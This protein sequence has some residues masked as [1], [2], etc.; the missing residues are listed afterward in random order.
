MPSFRAW[1]HCRNRGPRFLRMA[2]TAI[3]RQSGQGTVEFCLVLAAFMA[4]ALGLGA[5]VRAFAGGELP[6][7]AIASAAHALAASPTGVLA[8]IFAV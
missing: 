8:D 2:R 1:R 7:H 6:L 5:I 4:V 3:A